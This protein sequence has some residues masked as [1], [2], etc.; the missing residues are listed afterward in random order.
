MK[1]R[2]VLAT[3]GVVAFCVCIV[4]AARGAE[5]ELKIAFIGNSIT[6]HGPKADIGWTNDWGMAASAERLDYVHRTVASVEEKLK[7]NV[8][9]ERFGS[10]A[11]ELFDDREK[12]DSAISGVLAY[13]PDVVIL[14]YGENVNT[15]TNRQRAALYEDAYRHTI[16]R[17]R[18]AGC[19]VI[20]RESFWAKPYQLEMIPRLATEEGVPFV[21]CS[22]LGSQPSMRADGLFEHSGVAFHPGDRGM[23]KIAERLVDAICSQS[24]MLNRAQTYG[25]Q[26]G[27]PD[28]V[29]KM[30]QQKGFMLG[31]STE[32]DFKD[33]HDMGATL[34]RYQMH[35]QWKNFAKEKDEVAAFNDWMNKQL[36]HLEE[37]LPWARK[38]G[39]RICV[40]LH[41]HIGGATKEKYSSDMIFVEKKYE[42]L[43]VSTWEK[44]ARRFR[45]NLDVIYGYDLFNEPIDRENEL[46]KTSWRAVMCRTV[47]AIRALD[48]HTP[49]VIE[50]NCN[51]SPRGFDRKNPYGLKGFE[52]LP[53][54]NLIYSVHVYV[55]MA[56]SHQGLF[57]KKDE[58]KPIPY[59]AANVRPDPNRKRYPGDMG[60]DTGRAEFWDKQFV[61][62]AIQSV[63]DF[64]VQTGAR[65][66]VGEFSAAAY[67][68]GADTYIRDLCEIF[69]EYGWDWTYHAFREAHCW[70]VEHEG[71]SF[72]E[73]KKAEK[74]TRRQEI[75]ERYM[76]V[77]RE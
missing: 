74:K 30:P 15:L 41:T 17:I 14:A 26:I 6:R 71:E 21:R 16:R 25:R 52:P 77:G 64:Q 28:A 62:D 57:K 19:C 4:V 61:L 40:D 45:A 35:G 73:L 56:Y 1:F 31:S 34:V 47:E 24:D 69:L 10:G 55:P 33:L 66:F 54:D 49:I 38:Y 32:Q 7:R 72:Y 8:S 60:D 59:P 48:P 9:F 12:L 13:V 63:R 42:D 68:P 2:N 37:M 22:D 51:A 50:P 5:C 53:Y 46:T 3:A 58:Y 75:L 70:S 43:L 27:Y 23:A 20:V 65:I 44:I 36:D 39:I 18:K 29:R 11:F 76:K 67:A